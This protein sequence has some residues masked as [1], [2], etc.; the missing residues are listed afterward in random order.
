MSSTG[1]TDRQVEAMTQ[2][3]LS[4]RWY[5]GLTWYQW[6]VFLVGVLA[7]LFDC[8][9]QQIFALAR[10][11]A[12][13]DVM[14]EAVRH[15]SAAQANAKILDY[16]TY[17]TASTMAGWAVGGLFFGIVG[18]R[19]G[20]VKT[21]STAILVYSLFT[22]LC[23][24]ATS[25][26]TFCLYR[27]M[28]GGGIGGAF[29]AAATLIAET[30]PEHAR[31]TCLGLFSALSVLGNML[32]VALARFAFLPDHMYF[33]GTLGENGVAG[34]RLLFCVGALP[35]FLVVFV[36]LTLRESEQWQAARRLAS[37][38]LERQ[39]GDLQSMFQH[40]RWRRNT[41]VAVGL[42]TAGIV[43][44]WGVGFFSPELIDEALTPAAYVGKTLPTDV[45]RHI[46]EV[47]G[48]ALLLQHLGGF[49]GILSLTYLATHVGRRLGFAV[50][51]VGGFAS[52]VVVFMTL[53][54]EMQA[55]LML[56]FMGLFTTGVMGGF[57]IYFPEIFPTRFRSTGTA[58][59]YNVARL[60]AAI[61]MLLGNQIRA[62]CESLGFAHPF[63]AG[64]IMLSG[65]YLIGLLILLWAPETR[66]QPL[67]EDD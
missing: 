50:A 23:G 33:A 46:G 37:E 13:R 26:W 10:T 35:A 60:S 3:A 30:L 18:D 7:W 20:R 12:L 27:F 58:F 24:L 14:T 61:V 2:P 31:A 66:G 15:L 45:A 65:I 25:G 1:T 17:S 54:S 39:L 48:N 16:A 57:V 40:P 52:V 11:P 67:P 43:G 56:P 19:W 62:V 4:L 42:A 34:W 51:F 22:G 5:Q 38:N 41:L 32:G 44:V 36:I 59:G 9:D 63:R 21:L 47:R 53:S 49:I 28:M 8:A 55:Y 64:M 29:A 6:W